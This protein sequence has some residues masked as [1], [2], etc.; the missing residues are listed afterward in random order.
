MFN[1]KTGGMAA[2]LTDGHYMKEWVNNATN[3]T[4][5]VSHKNLYSI[6][7]KAV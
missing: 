3:K 4:S 1:S 2:L 5:T 6:Q 7:I